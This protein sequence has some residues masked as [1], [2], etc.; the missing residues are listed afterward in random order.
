MNLIMGIIYISNKRRSI[1]ADVGDVVFFASESV[2]PGSCEARGCIVSFSRDRI[3]GI[4]KGLAEMK[5]RSFAS[6]AAM[7][8]EAPCS[9]D[10]ASRLEFVGVDIAEKLALSPLVVEREVLQLYEDVSPGLLRYI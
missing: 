9:D 8:A 10:T 4:T 5:I 7:A 2:V 1:V 3:G 6:A